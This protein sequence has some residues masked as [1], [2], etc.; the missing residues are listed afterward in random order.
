MTTNEFY[1]VFMPVVEYYKAD[2]SPAVLALYFEDLEKFSQSELRQALRTLRQT[3]KF[4]NMPTIAEIL[5]VLEGSIDDKAQLALDDLVFAISRYGTERS[6][7]FA[8]KTIMCVVEAAGGWERIGKLEG[9][10]W[11]DFK[12]W[13][14]KKLY[15]TYAKTPHLAKS[16]LIGRHERQNSFSNQPSKYDKIHFIG[17][18]RE[19]ITALE[20]KQELT[21]KAIENSTHKLLSGINKAS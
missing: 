7:C 3:R 6:I 11:D 1:D 14:F 17:I 15:R 9:K 18:D 5:E 8:D 19:P 16:Y 21:N 12:K 13:E 10:E 20:F 2:L 4:S